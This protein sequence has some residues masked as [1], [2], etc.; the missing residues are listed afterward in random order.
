[1]EM[2][3]D[4]ELTPEQKGVLASL[5]QQAGKPVRPLFRRRWR[6]CYGRCTPARRAF[7]S[8]PI[9]RAQGPDVQPKLTQMGTCSICSGNKVMSP[10]PCPLRI[11]Q[12]DHPKMQQRD[13]A[14]G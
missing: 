2:N 3:H 1:M 7:S 6:P 12:T 14:K 9:V 4:F 11:V 5:S 8:E 13:M 10:S